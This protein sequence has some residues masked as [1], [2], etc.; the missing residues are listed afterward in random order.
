MDIGGVLNNFVVIGESGLVKVGITSRPESTRVKNINGKTLGN[1]LN[2]HAEIPS[3][4]LDKN[5]AG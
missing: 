3:S 2:A 4:D 5:F 1:T